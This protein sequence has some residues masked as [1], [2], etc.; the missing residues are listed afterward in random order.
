MKLGAA[1]QKAPSAWRLIEVELAEKEATFRYRLRRDKLRQARR[2][3]GRYLL[4]TNLT[5]T[6]PAK[7]WHFYLQLVA[8]EEAFKN[9]KGDLA[10]RPIFHQLER[11]IEAHIFILYL[12]KA[13]HPCNP[14]HRVPRVLSARHAESAI[15]PFGAGVDPAQCDREVCRRA[16]ARCAHPDHRR[17]GACPHPLHPA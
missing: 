16:D 4:R 12:P 8:V 5:E 14:V 15:A 6:D 9:L 17:S 10:I 11:R 2:R 1:R 3:E 7:L 13:L